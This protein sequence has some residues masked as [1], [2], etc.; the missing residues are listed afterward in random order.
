MSESGHIKWG[1]EEWRRVA[2]NTLARMAKGET[3]LVA[4]ANAM[5]RALPKARH[6]DDKWLQK[7]SA[8]AAKYLNAHLETAR[9]MTEAERLPYLVLTPAQAH[10]LANPDAPPL[11]RK[12]PPPRKRLDEGREYA[13]NVRWTTLEKAKLVRMVDWFKSHGVTSTLGR[14]IVEAQEL[15]LPVDRRRAVKGIMQS[16]TGGF[17][18]RLYEE[19]KNNLWLIKDVPFD[20][21]RPPGDEPAESQQ[22]QEATETAIPGDETAA[23][24]LTP[25]PPLDA[26]APGP[27]GTLRE[28]MA[29]AAQ[30]FGASIMGA[31]DNLL[32][33]H[34]ALV[35]HSI[36]SRLSDQASTTVKQLATLLESSMRDSVR[37]IME[38]ELGGPVTPP[39]AAPA[40][41]APAA[42]P[43][44]V[45]QA[46]TPAPAT[47]A[48]KSR[49]L[50]VDVVGLNNGQME[51]LVRDA[52]GG[53]TDLRFFDPDSSGSYAPHRGRECIMV[54]Q[55][56]PHAL[57]YKIKAAG[58]EPLY[59]KATTGHVIH[60]IEELLRA[61]NIAQLA[62]SH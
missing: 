7:N 13:G 62:H 49:Q 14:M 29:S 24:S 51:K 41:R 25:P 56:V 32:M 12:S 52:F 1:T 44:P 11:V 54:T 33:T 60:A 47:P 19:G 30:A 36:E 9:A 17:L 2:V 35:L 34:S 58:V 15:V 31:L 57:K 38:H 6:H 27:T 8:P 42:A 53:D 21:P 22:A 20:P 28:A 46:Q 50:K 18:V 48:P 37:A 43:A 5:R 55:R 61:Q 10:A 26:L 45:A 16:V 40:P 23:A 4:L 3:R 39:P 59:V